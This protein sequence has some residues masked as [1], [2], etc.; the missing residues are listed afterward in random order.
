MK[1][2]SKQIQIKAAPK[3]RP[4]AYYHEKN[5]PNRMMHRLHAA[6]VKSLRGKLS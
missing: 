3:A 5:L 2:Q 1:N 6:K 4:L